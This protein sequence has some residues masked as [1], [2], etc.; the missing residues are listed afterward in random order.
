M[1]G[2]RGNSMSAQTEIVGEADREFGNQTTGF[3]WSRER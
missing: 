2:I 1:T 3:R